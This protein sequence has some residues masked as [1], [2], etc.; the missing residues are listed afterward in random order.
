MSGY[1]LD[2]DIS[3]EVMRGRNTVVLERLAATKRADVALSAARELNA[4]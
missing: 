1:L 3:I 4:T 2:T